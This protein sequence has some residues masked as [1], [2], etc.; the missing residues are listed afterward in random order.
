VKSTNRLTNVATIE[1]LAG[2]EVE[3]AA[4]EEA[5]ANAAPAVANRADAARSAATDPVVVGIVPMLP[6]KNDPAKKVPR[7]N[8]PGTKDPPRKLAAKNDR[9]IARTV[10][11]P[12]V[13]RDPR[14]VAPRVASDPEARALKVAANGPEQKA[15]E[16]KGA[17]PSAE[18]SDHLDRNPRGRLRPFR[19]RSTI[20]EPDCSTR[21]ARPSDPHLSAVRDTVHRA[22]SLAT[23]GT[24]GRSRTS[25]APA[26]SRT[27]KNAQ[28][29]ASSRKATKPKQVP[30]NG[31]WEKADARL[32]D[33]V[34]DDDPVRDDPLHRWIGRAL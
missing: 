7:K 34:E 31:R 20:L 21:A 27:A 23:S 33:D 15:R 24:S 12:R 25:T 29:S 6:D 13:D 10:T 9:R 28:R 4:D 5:E 2:A 1:D 17:P 26:V 22:S 16:A 19:M 3:V 11:D 8:D 32:A 30:P 18:R 14:A